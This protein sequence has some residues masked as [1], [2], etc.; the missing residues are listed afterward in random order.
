MVRFFLLF[1]LCI[2]PVLGL[3]L[4][5]V[6]QDE[7]V[8]RNE[9]VVTLEYR[10][11][12]NG[13]SPSTVLFWID[14]EKLA[15]YVSLPSEV[16][17]L[18]RIPN[19]VNLTLD[20][21][22]APAGIYEGQI[23]VVEEPKVKDVAFLTTVSKAQRLKVTNTAPAG[24]AVAQ[25]TTSQDKIVVSVTNVG[26][27]GLTNVQGEVSV[28]QEGKIKGTVH[29]PKMTI[30]SLEKKTF[31][32]DMP[33]LSD[34]LFTVVGSLWSDQES[35]V[36]ISAV[37]SQGE[38]KVDVRF[39]QVW[40]SGIGRTVMSE[41]NLEWNEPVTV[42][43]PRIVVRN[44]SSMVFSEGLSELELQPGKN[45]VSFVGNVQALVSGNYTAKVSFDVGTKQRDVLAPVQIK[46]IPPSLASLVSEATKQVSSIYTSQNLKVLLLVIVAMAF[47]S[48]VTALILLRGKDGQK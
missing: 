29:A 16:V 25:A 20:M 4:S 37:L 9:K 34:G 40:Q 35:H 28:L 31:T 21:S 38:P 32:F 5:A 23:V 45:D 22:I 15:K 7:V 47:S 14:N 27:F 6:G 3:S 43:F 2:P 33:Q 24:K 48:S 10:V 8:L 12:I 39:P 41:W 19:Y 1:I 17:V 13:E 36:P 42:K 26:L 11:I 46:Y 30:A 44:E 18:P